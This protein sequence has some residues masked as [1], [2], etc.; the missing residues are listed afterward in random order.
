MSAKMDNNNNPENKI[1]EN[2]PSEANTEAKST[3][4]HEDDSF[5]SSNKEHRLGWEQP[6]DEQQINEDNKQT[7]DDKSPD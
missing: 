6:L 1:K 3:E 7:P 4:K 5:K 2:N